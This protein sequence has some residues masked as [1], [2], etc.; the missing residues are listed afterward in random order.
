VSLEIE[1]RFA[2][3]KG[4]L[5][6]IAWFEGSSAA[7]LVMTGP[8]GEREEVQINH[9]D[10]SLSADVIEVLRESVFPDTASSGPLT[11]RIQ[12][13]TATQRVGRSVR[14]GSHAQTQA[15][16]LCSKL[17]AMAAL[18]SRDAGVKRTLAVV[19]KHIK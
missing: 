1:A 16:Q 19:K 18:L 4:Q 15:D 6:T 3:P 12:V 9:I 10:A 14:L 8:Q 5:L 11:A 17:V 2:S 7:R 13:N